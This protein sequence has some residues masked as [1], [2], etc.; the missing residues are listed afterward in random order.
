MGRY[1][2]LD[3]A[4]LDDKIER[5]MA[6]CRE[7]VLDLFG[8]NLASLVLVGGY[9]RGEGGVAMS[10]GASCPINNYDFLIIL[11]VVRPW[12]VSKITA[13]LGKL[14]SELDKKLLTLFE[15][16]FRSIRQLRGAPH[17]MI[18][19]DVCNASMTI[20]GESVEKLISPG[21]KKPLEVFE[22]VKIARNRGILLLF[23]SPIIDRRGYKATPEQIRTWFSKAIIGFGDSISILMGEYKTRYVD[24]MSVMENSSFPDVFESES[25]YRY[26]KK[27]HRAASLYRL[28]S[29]DSPLL[30]DR[31]AIIVVLG[32]VHLWVMKRYLND[33]NFD[34]GDLPGIGIRSRG[35]IKQ[36]ARNLM[37]NFSEYGFWRVSESLLFGVDAVLYHPADK[38]FKVLPLLL[39]E[40]ESDSGEVCAREL[41]LDKGAT[42]DAI[43]NECVRIYNKYIA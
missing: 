1:T 41:G 10:D 3:D 29:E 28:K 19:H 30:E 8:D 16:S 15:Y 24:K 37:A 20:Y 12:D 27:L 17:I 31:D 18:Y 42:V 7:R 4:G 40:M 33:Q 43:R 5:D 21:V 38:L 36:F 23:S 35:S 25:D 13:S 39:Y 9:G 22:A 6:L 32:K 11:K 26:F 2:V 34:W 14:K